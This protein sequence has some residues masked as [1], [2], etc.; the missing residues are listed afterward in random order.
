MDSKYSSG[1]MQATKMYV[2]LAI[3]LLLKVFIFMAIFLT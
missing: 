3:E 1:E 2:P